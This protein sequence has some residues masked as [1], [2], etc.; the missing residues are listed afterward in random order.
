MS[1]HYHS[2]FLFQQIGDGLLYC[3]FILNVKGRCT[4]DRVLDRAVF[5]DSAGDGNSLTLTAREKVSVLAGR[6]I[7]S[8]FHLADEAVTVG[9]PAG[10]HD[11]LVRGIGAGVPDIVPDGIVKEKYILVYIEICSSTRSAATWLI[12]LPPIE[13]VPPFAS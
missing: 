7:V 8:L 6:R 12:G 10:G 9:L 11:F 3:Q 13:M 1:N 5:Q 2:L 4:L